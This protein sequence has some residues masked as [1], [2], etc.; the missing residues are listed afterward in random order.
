[1]AAV[2]GQE[3]GKEMDAVKQQLKEMKHKLGDEKKEASKLAKQLAAAKKEA[4]GVK[5]KLD[6]KDGMLQDMQL[7]LDMALAAGGEA[8]AAMGEAEQAKAKEKAKLEAERGARERADQEKKD[9]ELAAIMNEPIKSRAEL[10]EESQISYDPALQE[11]FIALA[12]SA[13]LWLQSLK[14]LR[15]NENATEMTDDDLSSFAAGFDPEVAE[16]DEVA[17]ALEDGKGELLVQLL[18]HVLDDTCKEVETELTECR[19]QIDDMPDGVTAKDIAD[20]KSSKS[21]F[22]E[23]SLRQ[24]Q[25]AAA[26]K[27]ET[28]EKLK[29]VCCQTQSQDLNENT[30][31]CVCVSVRVCGHA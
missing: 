16:S 4:A 7:K 9:A 2:F 8:M 20:L 29:Q 30:C 3:V 21:H 24:S 1:M 14:A 27:K 19:D 15:C 25:E 18:E 6:V 22:E 17:A 5:S 11:N 31:V 23:L 28:K 13:C 26:T 10:E 12:S